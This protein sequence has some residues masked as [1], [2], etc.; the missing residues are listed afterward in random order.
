MFTV[1]KVHEQGHI[2]IYASNLALDAYRW[3]LR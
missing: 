1:V 2:H 3:Q